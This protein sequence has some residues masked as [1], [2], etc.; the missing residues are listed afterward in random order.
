MSFSLSPTRPPVWNN[1]ICQSIE[2]R[3]AS[4]WL[5]WTLIVNSMYP[6]IRPMMACVSFVPRNVVEKVLVEH[7][8]ETQSVFWHKHSSLISACQPKEFSHPFSPPMCIQIIWY[9]GRTEWES[10]L[11][12]GISFG[13]QLH[14]FATAS[15]LHVDQRWMDFGGLRRVLYPNITFK[16]K[17]A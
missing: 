15:A 3:D 5:Q 6:N 10:S 17:E 8:D 2:S 4:I 1:Q 11:N 13:T 12:S 14:Q 9:V 7:K 16:M